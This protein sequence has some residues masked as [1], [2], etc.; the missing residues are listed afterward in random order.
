MRSGWPAA[1]PAEPVGVEHTADREEAAGQE[2]RM[3]KS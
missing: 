3:F 1:R 2:R